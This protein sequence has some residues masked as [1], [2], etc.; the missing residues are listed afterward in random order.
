M[1]GRCLTRRR[2][3][4]CRREVRLEPARS[5]RGERAR[6]ACVAA[7]DA[8]AVPP[9]ALPLRVDTADRAA[10]FAVRRRRR[11]GSVDAGGRESA[12]GASL[13]TLKPRRWATCSSSWNS[14]HQRLELAKALSDL[15]FGGAELIQNGHAS[16]HERMAAVLPSWVRICTTLGGKPATKGSRGPTSR[17]RYA[18]TSPPPTR[19][20]P[21]RP[22]RLGAP[23]GAFA[24]SARLVV[25]SALVPF[26]CLAALAVV[27]MVD[28]AL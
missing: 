20:P 21:G 4:C 7:T 1:P 3:S 24:L 15:L 22:A 26:G 19:G 16:P 28:D 2:T 13:L 27:A 12:A 18:W 11:A 9:S 25:A 17:S 6:R 23:L 10:A 5:V 14:A 8:L